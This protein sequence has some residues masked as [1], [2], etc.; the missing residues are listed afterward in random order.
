MIELRPPKKNFHF[1]IHK[2]KDIERSASAGKA[3]E[4][5]LQFDDYD[6]EPGRADSVVLAGS[7]YGE[8]VVFGVYLYHYPAEGPVGILGEHI[9]STHRG[10]RERGHGLHHGLGAGAVRLSR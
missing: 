4:Q 9:H 7:L 5:E 3:E 10:A 8:T 6:I 1:T 2:E